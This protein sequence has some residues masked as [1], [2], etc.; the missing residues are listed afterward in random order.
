MPISTVDSLC[1][2]ST[3]LNGCLIGVGI[4][5]D[6]LERAKGLHQNGGSGSLIDCMTL[7]SVDSIFHHVHSSNGVVGSNLVEVMDHL[8]W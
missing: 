6:L 7:D 3:N 1:I 5:T 8:S 2:D 4:P